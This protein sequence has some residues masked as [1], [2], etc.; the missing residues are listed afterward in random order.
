M[1]DTPLSIEL[2]MSEMIA[3]RTA[4][5]R[6]RMAGSM[7]GAGKKLLEA[8]ILHEKGSLSEGQLRA[9]LFLR[10][11]GESFSRAEVVRILNSL[12]NMQWDQDD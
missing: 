1:N 4:E 2:Q 8:G 10:M 9:Q 5:D 12:P 6:L 7:F 3:S 11:Y